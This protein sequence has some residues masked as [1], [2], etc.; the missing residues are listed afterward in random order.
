M[1][2]LCDILVNVPAVDTADVQELQRPVLH[3]ICRI[4]EN[5]FYGKNK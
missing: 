2:T 4:I 3:T 5:H 1:K